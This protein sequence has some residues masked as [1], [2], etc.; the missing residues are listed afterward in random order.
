MCG[1]AGIVHLDG[2]PVDADHVQR[3]TDAMAHRGPDGEGAWVDGPVGLGHRRLAVIDLSDAAAQPMA[4]E[5]GSL[6]LVYNG[7]TY[8]FQELR[9]ELEAQGHR[10]RSRS[11]AEVVLH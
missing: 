9:P 8:N 2:K 6:V 3:M 5:D 11:D 1:I 4:N 7:E 10:F